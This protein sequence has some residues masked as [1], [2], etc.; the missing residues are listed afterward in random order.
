MLF[1]GSSLFCL[2]SRVF[3]IAQ[4][5]KQMWIEVLKFRTQLLL[6]VCLSPFLLYYTQIVINP[7]SDFC[8][9]LWV[10]IF[11]FIENLQLFIGRSVSL[12]LHLGS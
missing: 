11:L 10:H 8:L 7:I 6:M 9:L 4:L 5:V 12:C 2:P 1:D 3:P